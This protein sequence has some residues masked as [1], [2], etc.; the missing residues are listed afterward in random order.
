MSSL[1]R[2]IRWILI[3]VGTFEIIG[4]AASIVEG[5]STNSTIYPLI[6]WVV[7]AFTAGYFEFM[8]NRKNMLDKDNSTEENNPTSN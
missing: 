6:F 8:T 4:N 1:L 5:N 2:V 3:I 7:I